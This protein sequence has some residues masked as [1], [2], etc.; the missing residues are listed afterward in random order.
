MNRFIVLTI[1]LCS[2]MSYAA[3]IKIKKDT[4]Q[5]IFINSSVGTIIEFPRNIEI[6]GESKRFDITE[7]SSK[8]D[9]KTNQPINVRVLKVKPK[10]RTAKE[11]VPFVLSGR[12]SLNLVFESYSHAQKHHK[13][14]LTS[15]A[16]KD[17]NAYLS[18]ELNLMKQMIRNSDSLEF[19]SIGLGNRVF[20]NNYDSNV[21]IMAL[22]QYVGQG[23]KGLT[24]LFTY[25]GDQKILIKPGTI[26]FGYT[27]EIILFQSDYKS[28]SPCKSSEGV[29]KTMVRIVLRDESSRL[30]S[31]TSFLPFEIMES[32]ND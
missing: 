1:T 16:K 20:L 29:C 13:L 32:T 26:D 22:K 30:N 4:R 28:L 12:N 17:S 9:S 11:D 19:P 6:I 2:C 18:S 25:K 14:Q 24:Y 5:T 23:L 27:N 3:T 31:N 7:L 8:V 15:L 21:K 10:Y